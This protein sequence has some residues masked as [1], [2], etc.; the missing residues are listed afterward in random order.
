MTAGQALAAK[1][2]ERGLSIEQVAAST[3]IRPDYL[4][5]I[6][7][8]DFK[9]FAAAVYVRGYVRAYAS[10]LGLV[11]DELLAQLP[12]TVGSPDLAVRV[13]EKPRPRGFVITTP[14][15][16][17]AA[18]VLFASAF[19][20]Y[21]WRQVSVDQRA[22]LASATPP[23]SQA[24]AP[25]TPT[26][27]PA[28]QPRPIVVGVRVTDSVWINVSVDGNPQ[29]GDSGRTLSAGSIVYFTGVDVKI[30]SGKA[31]ATF[32]TIDGRSVGALG[33]GVTTREFSSQT[34]S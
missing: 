15:V 9:A 11:P 27:S 12:P 8:E 33:V 22:L 31:S 6:E 25:T 30:T 26:A 3:R 10:Y 1:R 32:I 23:P 2:A 7:A 5:A 19:A 18:L 14:A 13:I 29:Y 28:I 17:A 34:S 21:A 4:R 16:A 20:G 24:A